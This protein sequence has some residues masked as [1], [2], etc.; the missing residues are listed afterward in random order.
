M[1]TVESTIA[2]TDGRSYTA[3]W[4]GLTTGDV[5]DALRYAGHAD[6]TVQVFGT[7]GG[8]TVTLQG[9]LDGTNWATLNDAQG[10]PISITAA[11]IESVTEAV[12]FTR[13]SVS[14]GSGASLTVMLFMRNTML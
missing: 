10:D 6:R 7:F 2:E 13:P 3:T 14:G 8:A 11:K 5:G 1:A 12:R 4:A 9:S